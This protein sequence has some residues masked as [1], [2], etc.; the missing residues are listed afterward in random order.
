VIRFLADENFN[1]IIIRGLLRRQPLLDLVTAAE[2]GL[3]GAD[4]PALLLWA[5]DQTRVTLTHDARTLA[6][7]AYERVEQ[8][9][10]MSGVI[11]V[12][13]RLPI[14]LVIDELLLIAEASSQEEW[15]G[16][17]IYLPL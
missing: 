2:V 4:D 15:E 13:G 5:V 17:V 10:P 11:E 16:Q 7:F 3:G 1:G 12:G 8:G 9:L 14:G 6:G